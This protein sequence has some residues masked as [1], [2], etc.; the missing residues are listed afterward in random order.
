M[1]SRNRENV[2]IGNFSLASQD[3]GSR[4]V[5]GEL[6]GW[7]ERPGIRRDDLPRD[8]SDGD[9]P[10]PWR[11]EPR[12]VS[13]TGRVKT[14]SHEHTHHVIDQL[15]GFC[16]TQREWLHVQGHGQLQ[17]ALVEAD[18]SPDINILNPQLLDYTLHFKANDPRK[19]GEYRT[20]DVGHDW[21]E[22]RHYGNY[23]AQLSFSLRVQDVG[24]TGYQLSGQ[25]EDGERRAWWYFYSSS[26]W[27]H[28]I[29]FARGTHM[30]GSTPRPERV[31][32]SEAFEVRPREVTLVRARPHSYDEPYGPGTISGTATWRDTWI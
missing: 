30:I 24:D 11:F 25:Y 6:S 31:R 15:N 5:P 21:T 9:F 16:V 19:Y 18:D 10:A 17:S 26:D 20:A 28:N 2:M 13:I 32:Y 12:Y 4:W 27:W 8:L 29:D 7:W 14:A 23:P 22:M 3:G 1:R